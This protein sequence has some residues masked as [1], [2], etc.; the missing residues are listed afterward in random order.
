M[1]DMTKLFAISGIPGSGKTTLA[2][3]LAEQYNAQIC[4][5]DNLPNAN[6]K[7]GMD[8]S[9]KQAWI[10]EIREVLQ[11][12]KSVICDRLNLTVTDRNEL[13][14]SVADIP[15]EKVLYMKIVPLETCLRRNREREAR[16]PDFVV[17]QAAQKME[18]PT[19]GEGWDEIYLIRE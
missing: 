12:G 14:S 6:T 2:N 7:E 17:E 18:A 3:K 19:K 8:G 15:C 4:S 5:Y 9:V 10:Q 13:L 11:S 16:L 1:V